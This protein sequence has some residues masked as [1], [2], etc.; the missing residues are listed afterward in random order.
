VSIN[1]DPERLNLKLHG[2]GWLIEVLP[3]MEQQSL[4]Q[5]FKPGLEGS[6]QIIK[7]GMNLDNVEFRQ[8]LA[9]QPEVL[10]CPS[11]EVRGPREDQFPF[12]VSTQ[13]NGAPIAVATTSYK[14]NSGDGSFEF[15][16]PQPLPGFWT[17]DPLV[18]CYRGTDCMGI[19][20]RY[21]YY[22]GGVKIKEITDGTSNTILVGEA[23]PE[24]GNSPAWSSDGDW[25]T[26]GV[27]L[28]WD[29]RT[30]GECL[31]GSGNPN[32][33]LATCWPRTR[34]FRSKHPGGVNFAMADGSV[35]FIG[36]SVDHLTFRALA[37]RASD[38]LPGAYR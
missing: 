37:T 29:W 12:S 13:V 11:D 30:A 31:D 19:F 10:A 20:W 8:A 28:N 18:N 5:R 23:S 6:W 17:Y 15:P 22:R 33:G 1:E 34:G 26:A 9:V 25:A 2:G 35:T 38:D 16:P 4:Y 36:D 3:Q 24:D 7:T 21:S 32:P 14:G 27:Q